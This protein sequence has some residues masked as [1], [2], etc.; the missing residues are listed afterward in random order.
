VREKDEEIEATTDLITREVKRKKVFD[1]AAL[2]KALE[3][4]KDIE[5]PAEALLNEST[6]EAAHKVIEL[7]E[8]LQQLVVAGDLLN[9]VEETRKKDVTCSEVVAS[10]VV[11]GNNDSHSISNVIEVE[12]SSTS[13]S[14]STSV[15]TSSDIDNIP[16]NRVYANLQKSLFP[17]SSTKNQ[18][19]PADDAFV[20][21]DGSNEN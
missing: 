17:S 16:L 5:V 1:V 21:S 13:A 14:H 2:Q 11:R 19:K 8:D 10:E 15:S 7:T 20:P 3:I 12:S 6:V 9:A 18:K 4:A